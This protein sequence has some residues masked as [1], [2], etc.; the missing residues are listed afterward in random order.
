MGLVDEVHPGAKLDEALRSLAAV[1]AANAPLTVRALKV[2]IAEACRPPE[3][4]DRDAV[5]RLV[6]ACHASEDYQEGQRAFA[7][8]RAPQFSGR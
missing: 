3:A 2:A 4:R 6:D 1:I 8:K 5:Q 7:E